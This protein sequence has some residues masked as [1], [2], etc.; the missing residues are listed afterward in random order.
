[1]RLQRLLQVQIT[2]YK[3]FV[4]KLTIL[5]KFSSRLFILFERKNLGTTNR[6]IFFLN[7]DYNNGSKNTLEPIKQY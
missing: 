5:L 2:E 1:M 7:A 3:N 6:L 4:S